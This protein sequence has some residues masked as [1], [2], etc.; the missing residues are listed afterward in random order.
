M[1]DQ[2]HLF[3]VRAAL[4]QRDYYSILRVHKVFLEL[5]LLT[6]H[7]L[8][9]DDSDWEV[10]LNQVIMQ[11]NEKNYHEKVRHLNDDVLVFLSLSCERFVVI[12]RILKVFYFFCKLEIIAGEKESRI[13]N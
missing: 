4:V 2:R 13:C 5:G 10:S 8:L 9:F 6:A 11:C 3:F 12:K 7:D 1:E